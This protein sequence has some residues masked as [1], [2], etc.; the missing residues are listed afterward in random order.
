MTYLLN[1]KLLKH[2]W[3]TY[4]VLIL[5]TFFSSIYI[6]SSDAMLFKWFSFN[7]QSLFELGLIKALFFILISGLILQIVT[8]L[9]RKRLLLS[10]KLLEE[11]QEI[12]YRLIHNIPDLVYLKHKDGHWIQ[13]NE[14]ALQ[15]FEIENTPYKGRTSADNI[16]L[17]KN[18]N[19]LLS[20]CD[21]TD[22][23]AWST[24]RPIRFEQNFE[25]EDGTSLIY[26][27]IKVPIFDIDGKPTV[28]VVTGRDITERK[29]ME[30]KLKESERRYESLYNAIS[31]GL[32]LRGNEGNV[33]HA[34]EEASKILGI[35]LEE[36]NGSNPKEQVW[37][38]VK[39]D[40][41]LIPGHELPFMVA[42]RTG[43]RIR[44]CVMGVQLSSSSSYRWVLANFEPIFDIPGAPPTGVLS[45]FLDI[46]ELKQIQKKL[47]ES[48]ERYRLLVEY[49]P[50]KVL[51]V[52][53]E[54]NLSF[55]NKQGAVLLGTKEPQ[56]VIGK[57]AFD[58][59]QQD[60]HV[61]LKTSLDKAKE[62]KGTVGPY[63]YKIITLDDKVIDVE[64][65]FISISYEGEPA[66][67]CV[68]RDITERKKLE[69]ALRKNDT[70]SIAGNLAAG[71]AHEV[72]NPL[73]VIQG[74]IQ[75]FKQQ[76]KGNEEYLD[77]ILE[78]VKRIELIISEFL[79]LS[80]PQSLIFK[81]NNIQTILQHTVALFET[82]A[83]MK[84]IEVITVYDGNL[85][86]IECEENQ[87]K[88]VFINLLKNA[89]E[90][91]P[92]G[93]TI[94]VE[95]KKQEEGIVILFIDQGCG[96]P[97]EKIAKLGEPFYTTK[98]KGTGLGL[99]VSYN[100]IKNHKGKI[101]VTSCPEEGTSF[102]IF[103]PL[104]PAA[105]F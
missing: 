45:T 74:F 50:D 18:K 89:M 15:F 87:L 103:L 71:V 102:E 42:L 21:N 25:K 69:E 60:Y 6:F 14:S 16:K 20:V 72:R 32:L 33:L 3:M 28:S 22:H 66:W 9:E 55:I 91:M 52:N 78:E 10:Q 88:Q 94:T 40:G 27:M 48:E 85:P 64:S 84:N 97:P 8:N 80:K 68:S 61:Q 104:T 30:S 53:Q 5:Y 29:K 95:V 34:N 2:Q 4:R 23:E 54:Y 100:I 73:T 24:K 38:Y 58:F 44:N 1:K 63:E 57:G 56:E 83:I 90:A 39:E 98:E 76:N 67:L 101:N 13:A 105:V 41:S 35:S 75:L 59:V 65:T 70:L 62:E 86:M 92:D 17:S 11:N 19:S 43:K 47:E 93:G 51:V 7:K 37:K 77:L 12:L 36:I 49:L 26:D 82:Q 99:M 31:G 46:T 96:I 81:E 79:M